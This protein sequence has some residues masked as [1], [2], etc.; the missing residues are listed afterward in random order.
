VLVETPE[1]AI[2]LFL[3]GGLDV[4]VLGDI[5]VAKSEQRFIAPR[6]RSSSSAEL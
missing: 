2:A 6:D 4:L 3:E 1:E 5:V